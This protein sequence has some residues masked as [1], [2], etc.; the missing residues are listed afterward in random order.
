[1]KAGLVLF[2]AALLVAGCGEPPRKIEAVASTIPVKTVVVAAESWPEEYEATGT[3][4]ART[5]AVLSSKVMGYV[6]EVHATIGEHVSAGRLLVVL[7]AADLEV[8][9]RRADAAREEAR[10]AIPEADSGVA[11]AKANLEL[12][13]ATFKRMNDLF[14]SKSISNQEYDE[15]TAR[16][17]ATE[18]AYAMTESKRAQLSS[19]IAQ[20]DQERRAAEIQRAYAQIQAPFAGVITAKSVEPGNLATPGATLLTIERDGEYRLEVPVEESRLPIIRS[21]SKVFV[22]IDALNRTL[23]APISEVVPSVDAASRSYLV[24]ID[25]PEMPQLRSGAFGRARFVLGSRPV[26]TLPASALVER[27]QVQ[28]VYVAENGAA[29]LRIV[30][31]GRK[32]AD[33]V[34]VL[35][36]LSSGERVVSPIPV[37]LADGAKVEMQQ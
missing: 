7:D 15:A 12:A 24:K 13:R 26:L 9:Y 25:L 16:L 35:A 27:G 37:A 8:N 22:S 30:S 6:R 19:K 28:S 21:G 4:R 10:S 29:R 23:E 2:A 3:V 20:T 33:R 32:R 18:A 36:G 5:T 1:M 17:K 11:A 34:E 14:A 31:T